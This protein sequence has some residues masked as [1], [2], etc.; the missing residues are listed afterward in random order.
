MPQSCG[1][2]WR[3]CQAVP[4]RL[5]GREKGVSGHSLKKLG[6]CLFFSLLLS[7]ALI[8]VRLVLCLTSKK[9][10]STYVLW[11]F[12]AIT[13]KL[14]SFVHFDLINF[15]YFCVNGLCFNETPQFLSWSQLFSVWLFCSVFHTRFAPPP[16]SGVCVLPSFG[17]L[18]LLKEVQIAKKRKKII[19]KKMFLDQKRIRLIFVNTKDNGD[20]CDHIDT[21]LIYL[22]I[23]HKFHK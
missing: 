22:P 14:S 11:T 13:L 20:C 7:S 5:S 23:F 10:V 8:Y 3:A 9:S 2:H 16:H 4:S 21:I 17:K 19:K 1:Q 15:M 18:G 6:A 12:C